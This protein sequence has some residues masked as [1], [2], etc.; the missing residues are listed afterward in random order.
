MSEQAIRV[1]AITTLPEDAEPWMPSIGAYMA[2]AQALHD[3]SDDCNANYVLPFGDCGFREL[4]IREAID[5]L[6]ELRKDDWQLVHR[7]QG[8]PGLFG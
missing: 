4:D 8:T 5:L 3:A 1:T 7:P 6:R 2:L